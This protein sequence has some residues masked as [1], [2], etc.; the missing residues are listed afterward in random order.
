MED[1][2]PNFELDVY[3]LDEGK[4]NDLI[5]RMHEFLVLGADERLMHLGEG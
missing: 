5:K 4:Y 2:E 3:E 1:R